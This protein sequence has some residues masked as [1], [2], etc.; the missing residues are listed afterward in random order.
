MLKFVTKT[1]RVS[2]FA[3]SGNMPDLSADREAKSFASTISDYEGLFLNYGYRETAYPYTRQNL[4]LD[5]TPREVRVA[6]LENEWLYAEFLVDFGGRLWKLYDKKRQR[7]VLYTNDVI[8]FRNLAIRNAWFS[9]GV[10]WNCGIIGHS[11]FTCQRMYCARVQGKNGEEVLR[12]YEF[13]RVRSVYYQMDFWLEEERLMT[14]V[15]IDNPNETVV[16]M[17]W[18]SNMATPEYDGGRVIVNAHSAYNN[19]DGL[20]VKKSAIPIDG[21]IDVSY[22][23]NIPATIDYFYRVAEDEN[24]FI[25]NV[26]R[27][28]Y[29]LLQFSS[30]NLKG[31]KLFSW[32]HL[33]G[34]AH[35]QSMLT[36]RAGDY[37]EIQAGLGKTQYECIPM[38]PKTAWCFSECYTLADL[39]HTDIDAPYPD[40]VQA[41]QAQINALHSS[42][43]MDRLAVQNEQ[44]I[45]LQKGE[46]VYA[47]SGFGYLHGALTHTA[48]GHLTFLPAD[49][50]AGY[51][52]LLAGK[53][54]DGPITFAFGPEME[55]L[56]DGH[57][58]R[59]GWQVPYQKALL[60]YDRRAFDGAKSDCE[61]SFLYDNNAYQNHLYAHIL[62]QLGDSRFPY[63]AKRAIGQDSSNYSLCESLT[64]LLLNAKAYDSVV[65]CFAQMNDGIRTLP[66]LQMYLSRAYLGLGDAKK[67]EAIL[68][69]DGGL[70]LLDFREGDKFLDRLY[71]DIRVALYGENYRDIVVPAQFDFIVSDSKID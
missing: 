54:M 27:D 62:Y 52:A 45:S 9:G 11:P 30:H 43:E 28:G 6:V 35:W 16:P 36:D 53:E 44:N 17:Y 37:V 8:R 65:D 40:L 4:Y 7:D 39:S 69:R 64:V 48:P 10:E 63:F 50:V 5:E 66:R 23:Q 46:I 26:D 71:R 32:G 56:L 24:T 34:S 25:A 3:D 38:P 31:R 70:K 51:M 1:Y 12:F 60:L 15:R 67:A 61:T 2:T 29:G 13:E 58:D 57:M 47:G 33:Q 14:Q 22:P 59:P 68:T 41:V 55:K 42:A 20:G 21:G 49:D 19:C 18:W